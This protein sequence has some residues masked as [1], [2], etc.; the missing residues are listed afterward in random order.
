M[1]K[2][3]D[4]LDVSENH[5]SGEIPR[6]I[7]ECLSIESLLLQGNSFNGTI[8]SSLASLKGLRYLDLS[9]NRFSGSIPDVIQN[10]S[11]LKYLNISFNL[12]DGEVPTDDVFGN[13]TQVAMIGNNKLCGAIYLRRKRNQKL[14]FDSPT[15]DQLSKVSYQ[16]LH[17]GTDGFSYRN[18][19]GSGSFGSVY[20]GNLESE[21]NIVA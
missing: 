4:W 16:D 21:D 19:I 10:I 2:N 12:L 14:S 15:I 5:L 9:R 18:L 11:G 1:L 17:Q 13:E 8:P 3:I 20:K 7:G 6:A